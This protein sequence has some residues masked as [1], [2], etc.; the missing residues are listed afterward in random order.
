[1]SEKTA[2]SKEANGNQAT[3]IDST[4]ANFLAVSDAFVRVCVCFEIVFL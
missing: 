3:D 2:Q 4:L 1:V